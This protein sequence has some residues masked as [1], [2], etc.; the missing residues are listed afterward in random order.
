MRL[1]QPGGVRGGFPEAVTA[2]LHVAGCTGACQ[3]EE[4]REGTGDG[5]LEQAQRRA[6]PRAAVCVAAHRLAVGI[7]SHCGVLSV[8]PLGQRGPSK[9]TGP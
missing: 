6:S 1:V 8:R 5:I 9:T 7:R 4:G 3:S 2:E